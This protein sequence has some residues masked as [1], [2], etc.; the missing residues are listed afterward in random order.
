MKKDRYDL[1]PGE[2]EGK[3]T[4]KLTAKQSE[5][6]E[7]LLRAIFGEEPKPRIELTPE[8]KADQAKRE[9]RFY[10]EFE[11][12]LL[13]RLPHLEAQVVLLRFGFEDGKQRTLREVAEIME[14]EPEHAER[15]ERLA[16]RQM[17][18]RMAQ[19]RT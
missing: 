8:Q 17:W 18:R 15:L 3:K 7:E 9:K 6:E 1:L 5:A 14:I 13:D 19:K 11:A 4:K 2:Y 12:I 16:R 10:K